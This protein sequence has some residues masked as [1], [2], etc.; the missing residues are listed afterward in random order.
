MNGT[1]DDHDDNEQG[2]R[3]DGDIEDGKCDFLIEII[4]PQQCS[5]SGRPSTY[6]W[7]LS[8]NFPMFIHIGLRSCLTLNLFKNK[9]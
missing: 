2:R 5:Q 1:A 3:G 8:K 9:G 7:T 6:R 4:S